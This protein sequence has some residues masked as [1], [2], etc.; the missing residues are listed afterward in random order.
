MFR[1]GVSWG[2]DQNGEI[3]G[4]AWQSRASTSDTALPRSLPDLSGN[5]REE[6]HTED[7]TQAYH[8]RRRWATRTGRAG[9]FADGTG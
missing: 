2:A 6:E 5:K 1:A 8:P 9:E 3:L 7:C 4:R